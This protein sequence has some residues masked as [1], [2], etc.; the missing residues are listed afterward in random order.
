MSI[1]KEKVSYLKGL[2]NGLD[3]EEV[4]NQKKFFNSILETLDE[5]SEEI[6]RIDSM[7]AGLKDQVDAIDE[8][9]G[10][11]EDEIYE[12]GEDESIDITCPH[13]NETISFTGEELSENEEVE[14]PVCHK[15]FEIEWECDCG[16][17]CED[18]NH[19]E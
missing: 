14:C 16:C 8:D 1:L 13:C 19:E 18:C 10:T 5:F 2:M 3:L 11:L 6:E 7:Q 15:T 17:E 9:L 4:E 12:D